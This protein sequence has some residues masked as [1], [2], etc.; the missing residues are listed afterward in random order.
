MFRVIT[1]TTV[2]FE[3]I[4]AAKEFAKSLETW[5]VIATDDGIIYTL[6]DQIYEGMQ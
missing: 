1:N 3:N 4:T 6:D 5:Y 2:N